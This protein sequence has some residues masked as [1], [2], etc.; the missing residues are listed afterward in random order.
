MICFVLLALLARALGADMILVGKIL[1]VTYVT[2]LY[3]GYRRYHWRQDVIGG[4][5]PALILTIQ[6]V[7]MAFSIGGAYLNMATWIEEIPLSR[8]TY[9]WVVWAIGQIALEW[10]MFIG[11]SKG[12]VYP[13]TLRPEPQVQIRPSSRPISWYIQRIIS[14]YFSAEWLIFS[15][16]W[17]RKYLRRG[18]SQ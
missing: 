14:W 15:R 13:I 3:L 2:I 6:V 10:L 8:E 7:F 9:G 16:R 11:I 17:R 5:Y 18:K 12:P 4:E 1:V